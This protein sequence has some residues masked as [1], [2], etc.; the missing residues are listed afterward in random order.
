M[1]IINKKSHAWQ[2]LEPIG[3]FEAIPL[4]SRK[5]EKNEYQKTRSRC[6]KY[7]KKKQRKML[8][9]NGKVFHTHACH[10]I[11]RFFFFFK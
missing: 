11:A 4:Q 10:V 7:K 2:T 9:R 8:L 6:S 1:E 5:W 3:H